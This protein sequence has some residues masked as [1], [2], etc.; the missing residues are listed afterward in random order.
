M[1]CKL[2]ARTIFLVSRFK[3]LFHTPKKLL[4]SKKKI[5]FHYKPCDSYVNQSS[6]KSS[7]ANS[8]RRHKEI[9]IGIVC[10]H[11]YRQALLCFTRTATLGKTDTRSQRPLTTANAKSAV[12]ISL[13]NKPKSKHI[14]K[15]VT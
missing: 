13:P 15:R 11:F 8:K 12:I 1:Q 9:R 7:R 2:S 4:S 6:N 10:A 3:I 14:R 5:Y